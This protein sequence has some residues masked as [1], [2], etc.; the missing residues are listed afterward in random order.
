MSI[1]FT[2][3]APIG[4]WAG[5]LLSFPLDILLGYF[6][7]AI[8]I[9]AKHNGENLINIPFLPLTLF[10]VTAMIIA[11]YYAFSFRRGLF[12]K[13][14]AVSA[15]IFA[16]LSVSTIVFPYDSG[17]MHV[18]F[19]GCR[20]TSSAI[21]TTGTGENIFIGDFDDIWFWTTDTPVK[22]NAFNPLIIVTGEVDS[23]DSVKRLSDECHIQ[24]I[25]APAAYRYGLSFMPNV[26]FVEGNAKT[27]YKDL[28]ISIVSDGGYI[29]ETT[30][31]YKGTELSFSSDKEHILENIVTGDSKKYAVINYDDKYWNSPI[32]DLDFTEN[33]ENIKKSE[34]F[35]KNL[36]LFSKKYYNDYIKRYDNFSIFEF[37]ENGVRSIE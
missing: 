26:T 32:K 7:G 3:L 16:I 12:K 6:I 9:T 17:K 34:N 24:N 15:L 19:V 37:D 27:V 20:D 21:I 36:V 13:M 11:I 33:M 29:Y 30:V 4:Y 10:G 28:E 8:N 22:A 35:N 2:V 31:K 18:T 5:D 25:V 14:A 23:P 1:V